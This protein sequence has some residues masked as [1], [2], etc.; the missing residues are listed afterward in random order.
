MSRFQGQ[1]TAIGGAWSLQRTRIGDARG[2]LDRLF[3]AEEL[4]PFGWCWPV[5]QV[6]H[7]RTE[8][9]GTVRGMHYQEPPHSE[10]KLV[11]CV[12]GAVWDVA[13]DLRQ[14]SPT[15]LRWTAQVLSADN[16]HTLLIPAGC[17]HGFQTLQEGCELLYCHSHPYVPSADAGLNPLD[18]ALAIP[19]PQTIT[20]LSDKDRERPLLG[21]H[22]QGLTP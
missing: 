17:A 22:F 16:Q 3:C 2:F 6:N 4:A 9:A 12:R 1:A 20:L 10:A 19:W 13:V 21:P 11:S 18:P 14:G 7:A 5:A 15:F 8:R